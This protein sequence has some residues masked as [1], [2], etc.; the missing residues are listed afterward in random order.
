MRNP[1][2]TALTV[3]TGSKGKNKD[4][5]IPFVMPTGGMDYTLTDGT[6]GTYFGDPSQFL[7]HV[8]VQQE[9][10]DKNIKSKIDRTWYTAHNRGG[11]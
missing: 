1:N 11:A 9:R 4:K 5:Q 10:Y 3:N 7:S 6:K 8:A 2:C